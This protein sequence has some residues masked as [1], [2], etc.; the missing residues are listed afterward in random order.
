MVLDSL[1]KDIDKTGTNEVSAATKQH[2]DAILNIPGNIGRQ[3]ALLNL[4][5]EKRRLA[6]K[7]ATLVKSGGIPEEKKQGIIDISLKIKS[8]EATTDEIRAAGNEISSPEFWRYAFALWVNNI[9]WGPSTHFVNTVSNATQYLIHM[10]HKSIRGAVDL[11]LS[12]ISGSERKFYVDEALPTWAGLWKGIRGGAGAFKEVM[13]EGVS[14]TYSSKFEDKR[15][16]YRGVWQGQQITPE[17][18]AIFSK[19]IFGKSLRVPEALKGKKYNLLNADFLNI[20]RRMV[21]RE[22]VPPEKKSFKLSIGQLVELPTQALV[23]EDVIFKS[24]IYESEKST[25]AR[26]LVRNAVKRGEVDLTKVEELYDSLIANPT[27][28]MRSEAFKKSNGFGLLGETT[29]DMYEEMG[30]K[31]QNEAVKVAQKLTFTDEPGEITRSVNHIIDLM[32]WGTGRYIVPFTNIA[33]QLLKRGL[34]YLP[35]YGAVAMRR[36]GEA[37]A[38]ILAKQ[39]EGLIF[40]TTMWTMADMGMITGKPPESRAERDALYATGWKP[41]SIKIGGTYYQWNRIEPFKIP[42]AMIM[43]IHDQL[44]KDADEKVLT[45]RLMLAAKQFGEAF[46]DSHYLK[47][48]Q[49]LLGRYGAWES[50]VQR[51]AA[52]WVPGSAMWR[53]VNRGLEGFEKGEAS[54]K[55][56]RTFKDAFSQT[57]PGGYKWSRPQLN[58]LGEEQYIEGGAIRQMLPFKYG[59]QKD[60]LVYETL[61]ETEYFP[62]RVQRTVQY[63]GKKYELT[64]DEVLNYQ[65]MA[66]RN[67]YDRLSQIIERPGFDRL[68]KEQQKK[69]LHRVTMKAKSKARANFVKDFLYD[70]AMEELKR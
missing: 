58:A 19:K 44:M 41:Y 63:R 50:W 40:A 30:W 60:H 14:K 45:E 5:K 4:N 8:G 43:A 35:G 42:A 15:G 9:L 23:A 33:T 29:G 7:I 36:A 32:P 18:W 51:F 39:I 10:P 66:G 37:T 21:G 53:F 20:A 65:R 13:S 59:S 69:L 62:G 3:L 27:K 11:G 48:L 2:L 52:S 25:I 22:V 12:A 54:V 55:Q 17:N 16:V 26:R 38:E 46:M 61:L 28:E 24:L 31:L 57:I 49:D 67:I 1:I 47:G 56:S 6:R 68:T 70:R 34:E 64:E